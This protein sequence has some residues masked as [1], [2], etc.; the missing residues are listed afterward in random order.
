MIIILGK[1]WSVLPGWDEGLRW[2]G[3]GWEVRGW[4]MVDYLRIG[5]LK[6]VGMRVGWVIRVHICGLLMCESIIRSH[7]VE[8]LGLVDLSVLYDCLAAVRMMDLALDLLVTLQQAVEIHEVI[9]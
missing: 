3:V 5:M 9:L 4:G 6:V 1:A 2:V 7:W 8:E